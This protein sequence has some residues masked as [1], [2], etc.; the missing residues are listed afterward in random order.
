MSFACVLGFLV[1]CLYEIFVYVNMC[2][3]SIYVSGALSLALCLPFV[4]VFVCLFVF[5]SVLFRSVCFYFILFLMLIYIL[6]KNKND[7]YFKVQIIYVCWPS[8]SGFHE[9]G[10]NGMSFEE[11]ENL[12]NK[13][14]NKYTNKWKT[15]SQR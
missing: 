15:K 10:E 8:H 12:K 13:Q 6:M 2:S 1:L 11:L 7:I 3:E 4:C 5:A 9:R 14:T